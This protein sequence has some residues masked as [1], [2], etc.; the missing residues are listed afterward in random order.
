[1]LYQVFW[2]FGNLSASTV[3]L[4][5][6]FLHTFWP[7]NSKLGIVAGT[8][9]DGPNKIFIGGLP[10]H[11]TEA[12]VMELLGA[13]GPIR[14]FHLVKSD[15][16]ATQSKGYCFVE[17]SHP[18]VTAIAVSGLNGM[19]LGEGKVLSARVAASRGGTGKAGEA[20]YIAQLEAEAEMASFQQLQQSQPQYNTSSAYNTPAPAIQSEVDALLNAALAG[21]MPTSQQPTL[22]VLQQ[23][24]NPG[25]LAD[26]AAA[27][28]SQVFPSSTLPVAVTPGSIMTQVAATN[29]TDIASAALNAAFGGAGVQP[30]PYVPLKTRILVLLN[31]VTEQDLATDQD[32]NDLREEVR[33]E[34]EKYGKLLSIKI[35]RVQVSFP[36]CYFFLCVDLYFLPCVVPYR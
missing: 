24:P 30:Q 5:H 33:E 9:A 23:Q 31:M 26:I 27:Y 21:A 3:L 17:Y 20:N 2:S 25:A 1:M 32:Y 36:R 14:A 10:Y 12:Q 7:L 35:P 15:P 34:C 19:D 28:L 18:E 16:A 8:V 11:L 4:I 13:F 29:A 22:A 6:V